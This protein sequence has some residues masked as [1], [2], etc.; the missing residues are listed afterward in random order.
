MR[1]AFA[2]SAFSFVA[3]EATLKE[4]EET[5]DLSAVAKKWGIP[6]P[7]KLSEP[8]NTLLRPN[9]Y[10]AGLGIQFAE[11]V[12]YIM[13]FLLGH[14]LPDERG[15]N[16]EIPD[17]GVTIPYVIAQGPFI[18]EVPITIKAKRQTNKEG[19]TEI[20]LSLISD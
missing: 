19:E 8:L 6:C 18:R 12:E 15:T 10:L 16:A 13:D 9:E 11:R 3:Q 7:V 20:M 17:D 14:L 1:Q 5:I 4:T 2:V